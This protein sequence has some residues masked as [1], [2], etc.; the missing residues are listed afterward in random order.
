MKRLSCSPL[1]SPTRC[2]AI[3]GQRAIVGLL[4]GEWANH[5][6]GVAGHLAGAVNQFF[7][8]QF[9][10]AQ[11]GQ[12]IRDQIILPIQSGRCREILC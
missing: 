10:I 7:I 12:L 3:E 9:L 4:I 1:S 8:A 6:F 5:R 2:R 11:P